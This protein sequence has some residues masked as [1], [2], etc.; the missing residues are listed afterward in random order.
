MATKIDMYNTGK[1][2]NRSEILISDE[3]LDLLL[4]RLEQVQAFCDGVGDGWHVTR[5]SIDLCV[6]RLV[7]LKKERSECVIRKMNIDHG[8]QDC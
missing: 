6:N 1:L 3:E 8:I 5:R 2:L 7:R 4:F